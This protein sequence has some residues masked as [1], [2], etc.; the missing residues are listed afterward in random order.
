MVGLG[1]LPG[2]I[3]G[4]EAF[5]VSADG[6]V[7]IGQGR[8]A[9]GNEAFLWNSLNGMRSLEDVLVNDFGLDLTGWRLTEATGISDDGRTI[10]GRGFTPDGFDE[11]W[12]AT[13]PEPG[14]AGLL[15]W[16]GWRCCGGGGAARESRK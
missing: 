13:I 5:G 4:S 1:D 9:S 11:G 15:A 14:T 8:S 10:V 3:F 2:G 12:I 7:V 6:S 16:G